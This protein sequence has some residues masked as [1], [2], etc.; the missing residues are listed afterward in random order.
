MNYSH[1]DQENVYS[2]F[3][4]I[5]PEERALFI[6]LNLNRHEGDREQLKNCIVKMFDVVDLKREAELYYLN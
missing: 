5:A 4:S 2:K 1:D 3:A 6:H